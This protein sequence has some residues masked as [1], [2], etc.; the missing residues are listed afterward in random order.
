M[1]YSDYIKDLLRPLAVYDLDFGVGA[2]EIDALAES[3]DSAD[4]CTDALSHEISPLT[5]ENIGLRMYEDI[6]PFGSVYDDILSRRTAITGL[7]RIDDTSFTLNALNST[8]SGCGIIA[9]ISESDVPFSVN[10]SFPG[11]HGVPEGIDSI[12]K[13]IEKILP[14]HLGAVYVYTYPTWEVIE[15][16]GPWS[17]I[18]ENAMTWNDIER[19]DPEVS[20]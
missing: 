8:L 17:Y 5:A 1:G 2:W 15:D 10:I 9:E 20:V 4:E 16:I 11:I 7:L 12:K 19:Y 3:F 18:E 14:C 13:R 6:L